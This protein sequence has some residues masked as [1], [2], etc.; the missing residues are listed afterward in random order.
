MVSPERRRLDLNMGLLNLIDL[1]YHLGL[2]DDLYMSQIRH[3]AER[4]YEKEVA[5]AKE[6]SYS[7]TGNLSNL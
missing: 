1:L 5:A 7:Q 2:C 6:T 3:C 4:F